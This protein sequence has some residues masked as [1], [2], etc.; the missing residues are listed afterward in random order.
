MAYLTLHGLRH[1][2]ASMMIAG[3]IHARTIADV[4]GH[5]SIVKTMDVYGHLMVGIQRSAM[6]LLDEKMAGT[7]PFL[8]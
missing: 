4:L 1:T 8:A 5:S 7:L 3:G 6:E 2:A